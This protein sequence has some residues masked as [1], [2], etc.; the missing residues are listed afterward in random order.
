MYAKIN[1]FLPLKTKKANLCKPLID[2]AG[3]DITYWFDNDTKEPR[4]KIDITTG[5]EVFYCPLGNFLHILDNEENSIP[6]W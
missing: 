1:Y 4:K 3:S 5:K 6:W 2:A